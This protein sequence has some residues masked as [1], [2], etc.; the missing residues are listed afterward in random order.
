MKLRALILKVESLKFIK[1]DAFQLQFRPLVHTTSVTNWIPSYSSYNIRIRYLPRHIFIFA[2]LCAKPKE[3]KRRLEYNRRSVPIYV[4]GMKD[5]SLTPFCRLTIQLHS[6]RN[7]FRSDR[8]SF[9]IEEFPRCFWS[10]AR[11]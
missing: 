11:A 2:P 7:A 1:I 6:F 4:N 3:F 5:V 9:D 8:L 10:H